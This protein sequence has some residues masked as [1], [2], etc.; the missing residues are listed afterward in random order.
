VDDLLA[1]VNY[2]LVMQKVTVKV[3]VTAES[4][5]HGI[6]S[7]LGRALLFILDN[8]LEAMVGAASPTLTI[9]ADR[10]APDCRIRIVDNGTGIRPE[11][12]RRVFDPFFTTKGLPH[13]GVGL[14]LADE[15][16]RRA[17]G[18]I[19]CLSPSP[20]GSTEFAVTLPIERSGPRSN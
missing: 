1:L 7:E 17:G 6:P 3:E 20:L 4:R 13:N 18:K 14:H 5:C 16:V 15:I 19:E 11:L 9:V 8:A 2:R 10:S 12:L